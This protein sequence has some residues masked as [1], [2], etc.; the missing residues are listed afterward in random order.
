MHIRPIRL[1]EIGSLIAEYD[2]EKRLCKGC[3]SVDWENEDEI[4]EVM[5][6]GNNEDDHDEDLERKI[7]RLRK[8]KQQ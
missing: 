3:T 2:L 1:L 4:K 7:R 8:E 5:A 6:P